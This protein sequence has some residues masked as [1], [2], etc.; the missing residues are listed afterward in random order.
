VKPTM[1]LGGS[2]G[3]CAQGIVV[4][5]SFECVC[6]LAAARHTDAPQVERRLVGERTALINHLHAILLERGIVASPSKRKLEQLLVNLMDQQGGAGSGPGMTMLVT[7]ACAQGAALRRKIAACV[8]EFA[9]W[10]KGMRRPPP[11]TIRGRRDKSFDQ[12]EAGPSS[13]AAIWRHGWPCF[14]VSVRHRR[15]IISKRGNKYHKLLIYGARA[16]LP[17]IAQL[18]T[19]LGR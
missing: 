4:P 7:D 2:D 9:R 14:L 11:A 12:G 1:N 18:D 8:V 5:E 15:Q 10:T 17:S 13:V 19:P 16:A 6:A 3:W